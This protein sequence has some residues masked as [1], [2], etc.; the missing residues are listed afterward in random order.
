MATRNDIPQLAEQVVKY[1]G[2][3]PEMLSQFVDH[4]YST[5][6][7]AT[8][9]EEKLDRVDMSQLLTAAASLATGQT[10]SAS[11]FDSGNLAQLAGNLLGQSDNS[12]H[13]LASSLFG[14]KPT[15][16]QAA[17]QQ[18]QQGGG[19]DLGSLVSMATL[20]GGLLGATKP[21]KQG[22]DLSDGLDMGE[23]A[24]LAGA[25][26]GGQNQQQAA[27]SSG[28]DLGTV[29]NIASLFLGK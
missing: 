25:F 19:L 23:M 15:Q 11:S 27:Q 10:Q 6:Q 24:Q 26:L 18:T 7:E 9:V 8:K 21:K 22:I 5:V 1:L 12:I 2:Q 17:P 13:T 20:A 29:A 14:A 3:H 4:P 16:Q 28:L